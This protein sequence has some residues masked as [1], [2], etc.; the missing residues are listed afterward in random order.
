MSY[1]RLDGAVLE[2]AGQWNLARIADIDAELAATRLPAT[3]IRLDGSRLQTLDTAAALAL[4]ARLSAAGA[5]LAEIT[6][7]NRSHSRVLELT[8]AWLDGDAPRPRRRP[9]R[10]L[11]ALGV[12][13]VKF[14]WALHCHLEFLGRSAA[15]LGE[16]ARHPSRLRWKELAAQL[17]H[18]CIEAIPVV[19]LVTFLIGMVLAYLFGM[20]AEKYGASIF[21]V[22]AVAIGASREIA[23]LLVAVI[24]AGRSGS[25]F[26]AQLGSMRLTEEIDA[27]RTLGLSPMQVLVLPRLLA[28]VLALPLL[29]FVGD[30]AT[31]AGAMAISDPLLDISPLTFIAR[32]DSRL[33]FRHVAIGLAKGAVFGATIA[34]IGC[35][36]GMTARRDARSIGSST[37]STVVQSIVA[38]ILLDALAAVLLQELGI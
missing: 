29:V 31:L 8:R 30:V 26:T 9:R 33:E 7:L 5:T 35:R 21:V 23:P 2:L 28:S 18:V 22:D 27:L 12:A 19:A 6:G 1:L 17:Q 24:M 11:A 14:G 13:V 15:A 3:G 34:L 32:V 4:L 10:V 25:A 16:L 38:V 36:A 20:Q 37:T